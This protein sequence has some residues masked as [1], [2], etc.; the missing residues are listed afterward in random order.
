MA[1][2]ISAALTLEMVQRL[3]FCNSCQNHFLVLVFF[4]AIDLRSAHTG[5]YFQWS[6]VFK[7]LIFDLLIVSC[8]QLP[9]PRPFSS[10]LVIIIFVSLIASTITKICS[11]H[12]VLLY[13]LKICKPQFTWITRCLLA[14][15]FQEQL[16]NKL[17]EIII[18]LLSL[19]NITRKVVLA[20]KIAFCNY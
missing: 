14:S 12:A 10:N 20:F 16:N 11:T 7:E 6:Y 8:Y 2:V 9:K 4:K 13:I 15:A 3:P 17:V 5:L 1:L 18:I 19:P